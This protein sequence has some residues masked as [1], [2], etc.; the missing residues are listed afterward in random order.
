MPTYEYRCHKCEHEFEMHRK[1]SAR[2]DCLVC[3]NCHRPLNVD[4]KECS[5]EIRT[6]PKLA[7]I[8]INANIYKHN[9][10]SPMLKRSVTYTDA[11][12]KEHTK[13]IK[14]HKGGGY[15]HLGLEK[16]KGKKK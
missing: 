4:G 2:E 11:N 13:E 14:D 3:P 15:N 1:V 6:A 10:N 5:Q 8:Q 9:P 12:G 7:E 16:N